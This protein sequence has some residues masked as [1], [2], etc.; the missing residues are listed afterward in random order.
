MISKEEV[1]ILLDKLETS[2]ADELESQQLDFKQWITRSLMTTLNG[3]RRLN[4]LTV[5]ERISRY[6]SL[7]YH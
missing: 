1:Q 5:D 3:P 7:H 4:T 6:A 2:I